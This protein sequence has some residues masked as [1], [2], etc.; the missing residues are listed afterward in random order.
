MLLYQI[1][2]SVNEFER[3]KIT[4]QQNSSLISFRQ[5]IKGN[6]GNNDLCA[7]MRYMAEKEEKMSTY[8]F[9]ESDGC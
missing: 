4:K 3:N 2:Y 9:R 6:Q 7:D 5:Q 8:M 1:I